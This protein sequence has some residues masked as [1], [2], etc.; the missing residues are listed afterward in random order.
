MSLPT[1]MA[2]IDSLR[3]QTVLSGTHS[4]LSAPDE[5]CAV[6]MNDGPSNVVRLRCTGKHM[7][8]QE[9]SLDW[10]QSSATCPMCREVLYHQP[11]R[12]PIIE[13]TPP[14]DTRP[15]E[16]LET[17]DLFQLRRYHRLAVSQTLLPRWRQCRNSWLRWQLGDSMLEGHD[18]QQLLTGRN[19]P[20]QMATV[21]AVQY[22]IARAARDYPGTEQ[23]MW[24]IIGA[25]II[26]NLVNIVGVPM[27]GHTLRSLALEGVLPRPMDSPFSQSHYA[28]G[29]NHILD[30]IVHYG[31]S[32]SHPA[33]TSL[34]ERDGRQTVFG[35]ILRA[36]RGRLRLG[37]RRAFRSGTGE[38]A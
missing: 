16:L 10:F 17:I 36:L 30:F 37:Q 3:F 32:I 1:K 38:N 9:C 18:E 14:P 31:H 21:V 24:E 7:F 12:Q 8:C 22:T 19:E 35:R 4:K 6:C 28:R 25:K 11:I 26:D 2:F 23:N 33:D 20:L 15:L 29:I 5:S 34:L 13:E 27:T